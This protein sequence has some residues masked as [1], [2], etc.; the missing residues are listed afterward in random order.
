MQNLAV[1]LTLLS[2][3]DFMLMA[4]FRRRHGRQEITSRMT[5]SLRYAI[6]QALSLPVA[7]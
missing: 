7:Y 4:Y 1:I 3:G 2:A 6:Q 5:Q